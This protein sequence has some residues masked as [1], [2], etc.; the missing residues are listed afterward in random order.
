MIAFGKTLLLISIALLAAC[1]GAS[2]ADAQR[3]TAGPF[4]IESQFRKIGAGGFPN[5]SANPFARKTISEFTV[6]Y[7]G[8]PVEVHDGGT[9]Y[10]RFSDARVLDGAPQPAVLA[11]EAGTYLIRERDGRL[12]VE[13][14]A[15]STT[16][17]ASWQWLDGAGGQP[18]HKRNIG[19]RDGSGDPRIERGG[20]LM[21]L[22]HQVVLDVTTLEHY[23]LGV[24]TSENLQKLDDYYA[25][26][27][28]ARALSPGRTQLVLVGNRRVDD[29]F[30]YA[31][32]A[33]EYATGRMYA[34]P[35]DRNALHF[36][37]VRDATPEW[38]AR[39]F[40]WT[41]DGRGVEQVRLR[42]DVK[43]APWQGR[44]GRSGHHFDQELARGKHQGL[45]AAYPSSD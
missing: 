37:S 17:M 22:N 44:M 18:L 3:V 2:A 8:T 6:R 36:E 38:I 9:Q 1:A 39:N 33:V 21:L 26:N 43:P 42:T 28:P 41:R 30:E 11:S 7:H 20:R 25:G 14:L 31:L 10:D 16:D 32:V 35:F 24:N 12:A 34:V 45:V 15:P 5:T 29:R 27:E 23:P 4:A 13:I 19:I 40:E